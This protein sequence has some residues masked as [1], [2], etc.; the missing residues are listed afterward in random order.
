MHLHIYNMYMEKRKEKGI[1]YHV[2]FVPSVE[3]MDLAY[4][5][6]PYTKLINLH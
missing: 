5:K 1:V 4:V 6:N 3:F 2:H